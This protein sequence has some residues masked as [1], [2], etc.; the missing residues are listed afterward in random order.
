VRV[1]SLSAFGA[2]VAAVQVV[3]SVLRQFSSTVAL[4][5][6]VVRTL[7]SISIQPFSPQPLR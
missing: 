4:E 6:A 7:R 1:L 3:L 2:Q 5:V